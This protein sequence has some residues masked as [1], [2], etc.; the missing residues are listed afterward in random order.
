MAFHID[1]IYDNG[2]LRPATPLDLPDQTPVVVTVA[3]RGP[4]PTGSSEMS[5]AELEAELQKPSTLTVE[6]FRRIVRR[7]SFS[8]P[9]LPIDF[10]R[11]DIYSD[12][13]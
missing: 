9:S 8:A 13:D 12:H 11:D 5:E 7:A 4:M 10:D 3:P 1:A 6:A 2:V